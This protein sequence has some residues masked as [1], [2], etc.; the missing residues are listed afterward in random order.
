MSAEHTDSVL[1]ALM[2]LLQME[3]HNILVIEF[4]EESNQVAFD[5]W[6]HDTM[7]LNLTSADSW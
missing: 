6:T 4:E 2:G 1:V 3:P 5:N 7:L